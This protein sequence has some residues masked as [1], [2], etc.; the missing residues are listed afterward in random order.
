MLKSWGGCSCNS[1]KSRGLT[2]KANGLLGLGDL[3]R[4]GP[5]KLAFDMDKPKN[6]NHGL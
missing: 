6:V 1:C 4:K 5:T 2:L 3:T